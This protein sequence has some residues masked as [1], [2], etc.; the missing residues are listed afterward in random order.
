M[1]TGGET[2]EMPCAIFASN[3]RK[4]KGRLQEAH[5]GSPA[6]IRSAAALM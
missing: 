3:S 4:E 6:L 2:F 5:L 1:P